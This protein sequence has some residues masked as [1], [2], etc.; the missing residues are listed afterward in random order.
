MSIHVVIF[1][2]YSR[3][4]PNIYAHR[5]RNSLNIYS[6]YGILFIHKKKFSTNICQQHGETLKI[7]CEVKEASSN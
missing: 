1:K 7:L 2:N 5:G 6:Y 4:S 3:N